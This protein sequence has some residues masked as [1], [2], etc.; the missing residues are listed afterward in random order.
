M[1]KK[2]VTILL[3]DFIAK[4]S[5]G[6]ISFHNEPSLQ[7]NLAC[8]LRCSLKSTNYKVEVEVD[9]KD[10]FGLPTFTTKC[11]KSKIDIVIFDGPDIRTA[12]E[13]YAIELKYPHRKAYPF[14]MY[15]CVKDIAFM[16]EAQDL[17]GTGIKNP[18]NGS[19]CLTFVDDKN[20]YT[21]T[22]FQ[23]PGSIYSHFR[24]VGGKT[25]PIHGTI[26]RPNKGSGSPLSL[27]IF[28]SYTIEWKQSN[29][30]NYYLVVI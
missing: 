13:K 16:E 23:K 3:E 28:G 18:F 4:V 14:M 20:F 2:D 17:W 25:A 29:K 8:F 10:A 24:P 27:N 19:F 1:T 26:V 15:S 30:Y 12:D 5:K 22:P 11:E 9:I 6:I 7:M 21:A